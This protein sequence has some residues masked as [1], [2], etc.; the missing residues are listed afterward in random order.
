MAVL[1]SRIDLPDMRNYGN[2][3]NPYFS[4][5]NAMWGAIA[6]AGSSLLGSLFSSSSQKKA[7]AA[8]REENALNRQFNM[9]EAQKSRDF[10]R[11]MFNAENEYN[12]PKRVV[13]R[14]M[15]AGIN[16]AL[17]FGDFANSASAA[18]GS[19]PASSSG[20][21]S[22]VMPDWSG[23]QSA[24]RS[25]LDA[26]LLK[27]QTRN[28]NAQA[29]KTESE[30]PWVDQLNSIE[31]QLKQSGI[32]LN[33]SSIKVNEE[34]AKVLT[35]SLNKLKVEVD[36]LSKIGRLTEQQIRT[37]TSDANIRAIDEEFSRSEHEAELGKALA[38]IDRI[39]SASKLDKAQKIRIMALLS[40]EQNLMSSA[41]RLNS[42]NADVSS[43]NW[44][45]LN[46][47]NLINDTMLKNFGLYDVSKQVYENIQSE[48][49]LR[50]VTG[51]EMIRKN[52][53]ELI[54]KEIDGLQAIWNIGSSILSKK[55]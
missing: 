41:S 3:V 22:P 28:I 34:Q 48:I 13:S 19:A 15:A 8:Q 52:G 2:A 35:E 39:E 27:A 43:E 18:G 38:M 36:N 24:G 23:I 17:A 49:N 20:G 37:V 1:P 6:S 26:E 55:R 50:N 44:S 32:N 53:I 12:D 7:I 51:Q 33:L 9:E 25:F 10:Q 21:I 31:A 46:R 5:N 45:A 47:S 11:E 4:N 14:L 42:N 16:P 30:T 29:A 40:Y 54:G